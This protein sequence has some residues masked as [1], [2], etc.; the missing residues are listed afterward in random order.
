MKKIEITSKLY[1]YSVEFID[2]FKTVL[3]S[4]NEDIIYVVDKNVYELYMDRFTGV[5]SHRIYLMD[6]VENKKNMNTVME[7]I[8]FWKT[9]GVRKNWKVVCVG[10]GISQDVTTIAANLYLRNIEWYFFPTTLLSM[11]DSCIGG[12]CGIN[13]ESY[14]NQIGVFYPPKKIFIDVSFLDTLTEADYINGWGELLKFS[15]TNDESFYK[16]L[17]NENQYI[18]CKNIAD[19]IYKGLQVK[20]TIIEED[21]FESDLRRVLNYG[22]T[23]GHALEAYTK[24]EIPHGRAVIWGIDVVNYFSWKTGLISEELYLDVKRLIKT[25]FQKDEIIIENPEELFEIIKTDKKVNGNI[26]NFALLDGLSHLIVYPMSID[27]KLKEMFLDYVK[28]THEYYC[29]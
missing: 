17:K 7:I 23:F 16:E 9:M 28:E 19:Y 10:G 29:S 2:D 1:D 25:A 20:K 3:K 15:L 18:P 6:P 21:E 8:L 11:C 26:L 13:L 12:K 27:D 24:N 22:H 5:D 14:K 4:F